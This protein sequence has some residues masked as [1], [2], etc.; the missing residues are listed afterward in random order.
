MIS[1]ITPK[2]ISGMLN[3][4]AEEFA[5]W[6]LP[7]GE[8]I[9]PNWC[10]GSIEGEAGK[11]LRVA[12]EDD[13]VGL[14]SDFAEGDKS[15]DLID[16]LAAVRKV[17][18]GPALRECCEWLGIERP[19]WGG[20]KAP[21]VTEP[22][23]PE[24]MRTLSKAPK[25]SAWL[26]SRGISEETAAKFKLAAKA[27]EA[28]IFPS[29]QDGQLVHLK[30]RSVDE[31]KFWSSKGT[32]K[33]LFGWQA[34][35]KDVR[36][37]VLTEGEMDCLA[38]AEYGL[39]AL[40]IPFGAGKGE[41]QEWI[42]NEWMHLERF[43]TIFL[44]V[45]WDVAGQRT[46]QE[47]IDRLGRT[48]VRVVRLPGKDINACLMDGVPKEE[49]I[50]LLRESKTLDPVELRNATDFTDEVID[51]FYPKDKAMLGFY[52][53]WQSMADAFMCE[54]GATTIL[55]GYAGH[56]KSELAGQIVLDAMRQGVR[57]CV[58]SFEFHSSKW[59]QR[60]VRQSV[61]TPSP[62][63]PL[64]G[65]AM[66]WFGEG[67]WAVDVYGTY[68]VERMLEVFE[69]AHRRYGIKLFVIDNFSKL[70]IAD[71]DLAGQKK[72]INLITEFSVRQHS[73]TILIHHLRK[74]ETD[75]ASTNISKLSLKGSSSLGDMADNVLIAWRNR[76][77]EQK[78]KD[79][80]FNDLEEDEQ[81]KL[82]KSLDTQ[83]RCEKNRNGDEEPR[84]SLW[85]D[86]QSHLF[87]ERRGDK[88]MS[89]VRSK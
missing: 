56:G 83:L 25:V 23:R 47:M 58:A 60:A 1:D 73:H 82:R 40:S 72:A 80:R 70:G 18:L 62:D 37:V 35:K 53:P 45:D 64:I 24:D 12:V 21:K 61:A 74:E 19:Q 31:K 33:Y 34:L 67:L 14:W 6:L 17:P 48:R 3:E 59:L 84:L 87:V 77:K 16:L 28:V 41:K 55:A 26:K 27:D 86:R 38:A 68:K 52:L 69:Y 29:M 2:V 10:V 85:F 22:E 49:I 11:S 66:E 54:Y 78:L 8:K 32:G 4:R 57:A 81:D 50:R 7:S 76:S 39:Q 36:S 88:P 15:G 13:K 75:M 65:K 63:R 20:H 89:Y 44:M 79:P 71:D 5:R 46:K 42:E 9:G 30:F 43:D 51:R